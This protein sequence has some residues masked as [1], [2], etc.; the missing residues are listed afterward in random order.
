MLIVI[1]NSNVDR[2]NRMAEANEDK[3][4]LGIIVALIA[5][6][7]ALGMMFVFLKNIKESATEKVVNHTLPTTTILV[8]TRDLPVGH[9]LEVNSDFK[10]LSIPIDRSIKSF[11]N[12]CVPAAEAQLFEGR[13]LSNPIAAE[14]PLLYGY[15]AESF[16]FDNKFKSGFL[17]TVILDKENLFG[18]RLAPGDRVD[19][20]VTMPKNEAGTEQIDNSTLAE[21]AKNPEIMLSKILSPLQNM[22]N[23][24][25]MQT[26]TILEDVEVFMIGSLIQFDRVQL[27]YDDQSEIENS[28]EVTFKLDKSD[29]IT[30]TQYY[31]SPNSKI[32]LLLRPKK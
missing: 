7:L 25:V 23:G 1:F 16:S 11:V 22:Q 27:G 3:K 12:K 4:K 28:N 17:K 5:G 2:D 13:V 9:K 15:L 14:D 19:I 8:A 24:V 29:A 18:S 6:L 32:S 20:L 21:M 10:E 30:L 31:N 26:I